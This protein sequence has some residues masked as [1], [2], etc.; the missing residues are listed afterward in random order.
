MRWAL[1]AINC[2]LLSTGHHLVPTVHVCYR[3][4]MSATDCAYL[5]ST[6]HGL[7]PTGHATNCACLLL[8]V[9]GLLPTVHDLL[10]TIHDLLPTVRG[11]LPTV[12]IAD[13]HGLLST[14][15][16]DSKLCMVCNQLCIVSY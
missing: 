16:S 11:L 8:P 12:H 5:L 4:C 15:H 1:S 13:V 6:V 9:H 2:G 14:V 7:L 10:P 3:L